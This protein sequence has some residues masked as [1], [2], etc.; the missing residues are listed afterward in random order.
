MKRRDVI[1]GLT[2]LPLGGTALQSFSSEPGIGNLPSAKAVVK[3]PLI[4]GPQIYQSIGVEPFVNCKGTNTIM[5]GSVTRPAVREA[6]EAASSYNVQLD[7][8]AFGVGERL[9]ELTGAEWGMVS[10]GC[11][12]GLKLV[13]IACLS[14]GDPEKLIRIPDL[15]GFEKTEVIIPRSTRNFYDHGVR[16]AGVKVVMVDT[17][18]ELTSAINPR[19]LM[20]Y[21]QAECAA[22]LT[23]EAVGRV[24]KAKNIPILC[25][26]ASHILTVPNVH[27][28]KGASVVVYSGGKGLK[29]PGCAGLLLGSKDI[30]MAAWQASAPHHGPGRDNKLGK[31]EH[32]GMLAAV[33]AWIKMDHEAEMK[34]WLS[35]LDN[36][37]KRV[38]AIPGVKTE[39]KK[40]DPKLID[41][42]TPDLTISWDPA[43][44]NITGAE[45]ADELG[46]TPPRVALNAGR[47]TGATS[48]SIN[49]VAYMMSPGNDKIAGDR[50]YEVLS[51]K[52][53][54]KP[55][56]EMK[57]PAANIAG[58][59]DVTVQFS[60]GKAEHTFFIDKQD[61]NWLQ[62]THKGTFA[63]RDMS[64]TIEGSQV[65]FQSRYAIPGDAVTSIFFGT[66]S[67]DTITGDID[68]G[69]Y[70][71]AKFVAKKHVF[72][73]E[74]RPVVI[75]NGRPQ[76]S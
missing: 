37:A 23:L 41:H 57:A 74:K 1:K 72:P 6:M 13:T 49:L 60:N 55:K 2:L 28:A 66:L 70:V 50:I 32:I 68:L 31:E 64:G 7:E 67:G 34:L 5:G 43:K 76:A 11:A 15:S 59:W 65:K 48:T 18:E 36:I 45:V 47:N 51:R 10:A 20:I 71:T 14:G 69:E 16:N 52:R 12:A 63:T 25:D 33:E 44:L 35:W 46:H 56:A 75:P 24:A 4:T 8:L 27:L 54:P 22:P 62:G 29:G 58:R 30:L 21:M 17:L 3:G 53:E 26:A 61:G 73:A 40:P 38:A 19:T 9:A 42:V 39:I